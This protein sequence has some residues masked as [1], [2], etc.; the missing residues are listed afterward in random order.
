[1]RPDVLGPDP[2]FVT[3][4]GLGS[5]ICKVGAPTPQGS[6]RN[7]QQARRGTR[8]GNRSDAP[9]L[10]PEPAAPRHQSKSCHSYDVCR[11]NKVLECGVALVNSLKTHDASDF[12]NTIT[13]PVKQ[14][15]PA[16][17]TAAR[18]TAGLPLPPASLA[19]GAL[20]EKYDL[21]LVSNRSC[22]EAE[23]PPHTAHSW[24][25]CS[26]TYSPLAAEINC[27]LDQV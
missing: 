10:T 9:P 23:G 20:S 18:H 27:T 16:P 19:R 6:L 13:T 8:S 14:C 5:L 7:H 21:S 22:S 17:L 4:V 15:L 2:A 26:G 11:T 1:M 24:L 25:S 3:S 12:P